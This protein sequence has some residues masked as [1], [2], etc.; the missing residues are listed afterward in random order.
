MGVG[1][2]SIVLPSMMT[3]VVPSP[4]SS[5]CVRATSNIDLAAGCCTL[6]CELERNK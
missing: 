6:I 1:G 3:E 4:V 2:T 5:S